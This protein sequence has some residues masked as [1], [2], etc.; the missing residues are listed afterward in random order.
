MSGISSARRLGTAFA[1][2]ASLSTVASAQDAFK[3]F[4]QLDGSVKM[5]KLNAFIAPG[6]ENSSAQTLRDV[7]LEAKLGPDSGPQ[8]QGLSWYVFSPFAGAD[9]KLPLVASSKG[10]S[11]SFHLMPGDYF[12]NVS[13][14]RA[15]VTKKLTVPESGVLQKQI[16]VLDAGG[17]VLNAVSG[18]D[19][20]IPPDELSFSIYSNDAKEDGERGLVMSGVKPNT[21]VGLSAGTYHVVSEYGAVNAVIRADIQ[22]ETGKVTEATIQHKAA[23]ITFKLV[24]DAGGEAIADTAWSILTSSGDIVGESLSAFPTMVLAEGQYTAIARNKDKIYQRDFAVAAGKNTDIE[25]LMKEQQPQDA[26]DQ[27]QPAQQIPIPSAQVQQNQAPQT[28]PAASGQ[29]HPLPTYEQLAPS[30]GGDDGES[31]D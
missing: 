28:K 21:L 5:P 10:G 8:L 12:V 13:F 26:N 16:M 20:R 14:G 27:Q 11:A 7:S 24:S 2:L 3:E 31:M 25:V 1:I 19:V 23:K 9:G 18:S 29:Q 6:G 17:M 15:G 4:K 30:A 22:V